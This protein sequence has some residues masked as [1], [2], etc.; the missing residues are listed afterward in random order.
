MTPLERFVA[1]AKALK[2]D[3]AQSR[4]R[5]AE[6]LQNITDSVLAR[7]APAAGAIVQRIPTPGRLHDLAE[8]PEKGLVAGIAAAVTAVL[9]PAAP[10]VGTAERA[11]EK[12]IDRARDPDD[13]GRSR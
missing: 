13:G 10:I 3:I 7:H 5:G 11:V 8:T 4:G 12:L 6:R 9:P 2:D 1:T